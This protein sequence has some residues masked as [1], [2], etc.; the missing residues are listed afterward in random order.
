M[1]VVRARKA[2]VDHGSKR[3]ISRFLVSEAAIGKLVK[4]ISAGTD[5][6]HPVTPRELGSGS[7]HDPIHLPLRRT[8][9]GSGCYHCTTEECC[10]VEFEKI[11]SNTYARVPK[12]RMVEVS[13]ARQLCAKSLLTPFVT[14]LVRLMNITEKDTF[15]DFGCG[16]GSVLFQVAFMTGAKCVGV[17]ISEHNAD[18]ARE[19]WQLLR[20]VLEKKYDRPMPRVEIITADL[21]ELL[22]TPTYFDEEE[23]Q[24]AILISNLLFP[25][26]LTHFLSER[27]RSAPVGT[28]I[29]CFDDLYPHARSVASYR[30]PGAFELFEMK[31]YFWQEM[32]VEWCSMEGR[33]FIHTRK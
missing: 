16:N 24:T 7:P 31:D 30:D 15:Y 27:L 4:D 22:S 9:N 28:R 26:P 23:G 13:G 29:L 14:R 3:S 5:A 21:A 33:F 12:K 20:Q 32:S 11:L 6:A 18:V 8:P 17:E 25:K 2:R 10:C 1:P 19:A